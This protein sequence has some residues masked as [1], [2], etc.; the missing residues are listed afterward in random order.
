MDN[1]WEDYNRKAQ[2][3][4]VFLRAGQILRVFQK[5]PFQTLEI[6]SI[7]KVPTQPFALVVQRFVE[8]TEKMK[9]IHHQ[10]GIGKLPLWPC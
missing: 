2:A 10:G 6:F 4:F 9:S 1:Y 8:I 7:F 5:R 3:S